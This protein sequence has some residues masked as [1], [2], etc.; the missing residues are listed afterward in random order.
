MKSLL[1]LK[2][3]IEQTG[4]FVRMVGCMGLHAWNA[5]WCFLTHGSISQSVDGDGCTFIIVINEVAFFNT[6]TT[7]N[8]VKTA[9]VCT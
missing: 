3:N 9:A 1:S 8:C 6:V 4:H 5:T 2:S 7:V